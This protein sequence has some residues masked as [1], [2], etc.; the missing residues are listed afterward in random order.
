MRHVRTLFAIA[1]LAAIPIFSAD[2][3]AAAT[4]T[5]EAAVALVLDD[6]HAA[7][8]V[9]AAERYFGHFTPDAVFLGTDATER[10]TVAEFREYASPHFADGGGWTYEPTERHV[11]FSPDGSVAW[12]D[13]KLRN[14][15]YGEVRGTGVL[16]RTAAGWKIAHYSM[17]FLVPNERAPAVVLAISGK[18]EAAPAGAER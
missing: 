4:D 16:R 5:A 9:G 17:T 2:R 12:F 18:P 1:C 13:E 10:W 7:A 14:E 8:S 11:I 3:P 15:K 6:F